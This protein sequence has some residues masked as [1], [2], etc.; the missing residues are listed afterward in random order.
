MGKIGYG[1]T[2]QETINLASDY[3]VHLGYRDRSHP[4]S[5]RWLYSFIDRWPELKVQKPRKLEAARARSATKENIARYFEELSQVI[6]KH[7]F[8][9]SPHAIFNID[10]KGL[11]TDV[12]PPKIVAGVNCKAQTVTSGKSKTVTMIAAVSAVGGNVPPY[13]VFPG[14][15]MREELLSEATPGASGTVSKTGW[16]NT[17][18]F[19]TYMKDHLA[20]YLPAREADSPVLILYDGHKSHVSL[21]LIE[22][23]RQN[24][25]ILFVLP[26]HTSHLLQPLDIGCYGPFQTTWIRACHSFLRENSGRAISK[27]DM[28]DSM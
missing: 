1:Y 13:F 20:K 26:P 12:T 25:I 4:L 23:A 3:A 5:L 18:V 14:Q 22:W 16:S 15:R 27:H 28:R 6:K 2:R 17:D 11:S 7:S 21:G 10:E 8:D 24:H 19:S 9:N